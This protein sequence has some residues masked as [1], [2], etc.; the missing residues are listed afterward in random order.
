[1]TQVLVKEQVVVQRDCFAAFRLLERIA[2][3]LER[4]S[5][6]QVEVI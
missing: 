4:A 1:M 2:E 5:P 6:R 3:A